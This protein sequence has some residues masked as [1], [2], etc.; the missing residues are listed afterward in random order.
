MIM[1]EFILFDPKRNAVRAVGFY[2][3]S[4]GLSRVVTS[5]S[6][7][8]FVSTISFVIG[9]V[10]LIMGANL[11]YSGYKYLRDTSRGLI[12]MI[13]STSIL[14]LMQTI[15]LLMNY[16][17]YIMTGVPLYVDIV[18]Y[19]I[20]FL[21]Y[22][23]LLLILDTKEIRYSTLL[24][25]TNTRIESIRVTNTVGGSLMLRRDDGLVLK[26]MFDDRS[27]WVPLTDGGPAESEKR[28]VL[29]NGRIKSVMI[30][31][32][33]SGHDGIYVTMANAERGSVMV[34]NRFS[35]SEVYADGDDAY[36]ASLMLFDGK[37]MLMTLEVEPCVPDEKGA[38]A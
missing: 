29:E 8:A 22:I 15:I 38:A 26:H 35:V 18:P 3:V 28:L 24:Q 5:I 16:Q 2:A 37:R 36:F 21:Q 20:A 4:L 30:L 17:A 14:A 6:T 31:Q 1:A 7:F 32:K 9:G 27:S 33:W 34:A 25:Q 19:A 23:V 10:T 13:V 12:G 11:L